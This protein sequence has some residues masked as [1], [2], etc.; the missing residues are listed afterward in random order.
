MGFW[1][2]AQEG[3]HLQVAGSRPKTKEEEKLDEAAPKLS[4]NQPHLQTYPDQDLRAHNLVT[5]TSQVTFGKSY[6]ASAPL[7]SERSGKVQLLTTT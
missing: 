5:P 2:P 4:S 3:L 7:Y 6:P 1:L